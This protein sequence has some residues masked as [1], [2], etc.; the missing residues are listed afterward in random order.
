MSIS[1]R[2]NNA[3]IEYVKNISK[4][5]FEISIALGTEFVFSPGQYVWL[6]LLDE[7][8]L[9]I[10]RKAFSIS[11]SN[12]SNKISI[13]ARGGVS[14][15][16]KK[17]FS[18]QPGEKVIVIGPFGSSF[19]NSDLSKPLIMIGRGAGISPFLSVIRERMRLQS[20]QIISMFY[21]EEDQERRMYLTEIQSFAQD[22]INAH[23]YEKF[24]WKH[25]KDLPYID[26][27]TFFI[28]GPQ[29]FVDN[30]YKTLIENEITQHQMRFEAEYPYV[31]EEQKQLQ[32]LFYKGKPKLPT[33]DIQESVIEQFEL[34]QKLIEAS[35]NH[36]VVTDYNGKIL[37]ANSAAQR[38]TGFTFKEMEGNT[39]RLWGGLMD[40]A[41]YKKLWASKKSGEALEETLVNR[42]KNGELY[43]A[44]AHMSPILDNNIILGWVATE[45]DITVYETQRQ[46]M[47]RSN[48]DLE[49]G[50]RA[51]LNILEDNEAQKKELESVTSRLSLATKAGGIG[52]WDWDITRNILTWDKQM[53]DLYGIKEADFSGA[54]EAWQ[55]GLHPDDKERGDQEIQMAIKGEKEFD[56]TFRVVWPDQSIHYIRAFANVL[57]N[58]NN[59][60]IKMVGVNFD[61]TREKEL[62]HIKDD[63]L[64]L[65]SHELRTPM[66]AIRG[67]VS[68]VLEGDYGEVSDNIKQP[69]QDVE[70]S[71][72]NLINLVNDM[73][74]VSRIEAGRLKFDLSVFSL[75]E[76]IDESCNL[77]K[78]LAQERGLELKYEIQDTI[79]VQAD[80][81]KV[82]QIITNLV[83]NSLKFTEQGTITVDTKING[84]RAVISVTDQGVGISQKDQKKLFGKFQQIDSKLKGKPKGTGLGLYLSR[85]MARKMGGELWISWSEPGKGS[86]FSFSVPLANSEVAKKTKAS[87]DKEAE[88][89]PDQ[90]S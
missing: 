38:I 45:E 48:A 76:C 85:A 32:N 49:D 52:V 73:L 4:D 84:D 22:E 29:D 17:L 42:K 69:L 56:T 90:K 3:Q 14:D 60:A 31:N 75:K 88:M 62:E 43:Y 47:E 89:H 86:T 18:V 65:A 77:L 23:V 20:D 82:N 87:I 46:H 66:T 1:N 40:G 68:M 13:I 26:T 5:T 27:A 44:K 12:G 59:E 64:S 24:S 54:Y 19:V 50:R 53:Y 70:K 6:V 78:N 35:T 25:F 80:Q 74:N 16:K 28:S 11:N 9:E 21:Y 72:K 79:Q 15:Y 81:E 8:E 63:F 2:H 55:N 39:P 37:Y 36:I 41:F 57:R 58:D 51:I 7:H 10:G 30:V 67:L 71:T 61:I 34:L 83:G 33:E